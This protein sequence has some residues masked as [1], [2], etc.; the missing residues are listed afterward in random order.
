MQTYLDKTFKPLSL[1]ECKDKCM[2]PAKACRTKV[3]VIIGHVLH[4]RSQRRQNLETELGCLSFSTILKIQTL[5]LLFYQGW[6]IFKKSILYLI[7]ISYTIAF[8]YSSKKAFNI[9]VQSQDQKSQ[10]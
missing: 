10:F 6:V 7:I 3:D 8:T 5:K 4:S 2:Q 1:Q 9:C